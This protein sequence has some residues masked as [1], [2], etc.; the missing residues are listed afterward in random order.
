MENPIPNDKIDLKS[1]HHPEEE[2]FEVDVKAEG[3]AIPEPTKDFGL[4]HYSFQEVKK[5][6][7][8]SVR[9]EK[10]S[11]QQPKTKEKAKSFKVANEKKMEDKVKK[12]EQMRAKLGLNFDVPKTVKEKNNE[13]NSSAEASEDEQKTEEQKEKARKKEEERVRK[14]AKMQSFKYQKKN[15]GQII[16][17]ANTV[18]EN[19]SDK[20]D[21]QDSEE[22]DHKMLDYISMDRC[23]NPMS[24]VMDKGSGLAKTITNNLKIKQSNTQS[25]NDQSEAL[26]FQEYNEGGAEREDFETALT[27]ALDHEIGF[28]FSDEEDEK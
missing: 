9:Y 21:E 2:K 8:Y 18:Q 13:D 1:L 11:E 22:E 23:T 16:G 3:Q 15:P 7:F 6:K 12:L 10:K 5:P 19:E 20:E 26:Q 4:G 28:T 17:E 24:N 27:N 14:S 25:T